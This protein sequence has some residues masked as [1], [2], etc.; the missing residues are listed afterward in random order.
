MINIPDDLTLK[1]NLVTLRPP[2]ADDYEKFLEILL[3][4]KTDSYLGP[5]KPEG[6][7]TKE[8]VHKLFSVRLKLQKEGKALNRCIETNDKKEMIGSAGCRYISFENK[9]ANMGIVLSPK[10]WGSGVAAETGL[11]L[12]EYLFEKLGM[13]RI[14]FQM[15]ENNTR[16]SRLCASLGLK[17]DGIRKNEDVPEL[18]NINLLTFSLMRNELQK[19]KTKLNDRI[20]IQRR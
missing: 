6:G 1:G 15:L 8:A 10:Y 2:R 9:T 3:E 5:L 18:K 19:V 16:A 20:A 13:G 17:L 14:E 12:G 7:W 11:L 4:E